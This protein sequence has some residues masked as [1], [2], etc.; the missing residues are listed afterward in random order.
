MPRALC[1]YR[2]VGATNPLDVVTSSVQVPV[3]GAEL[4]VLVVGSAAAGAWPAILMIHENRGMVPYMVAV[5]ADL[6]AAGYRVVAPDLL[7]RIGGTASFADDP[8]SVSTRQIDNDTHVADLRVVYDSMEAAGSPP[9]VVGFCFGAEMGWQLITQRTPRGAVLY[10]GIGPEPEA[11]RRITSPVYAVYA[12]DDPRVNAT[13]AGLTPA[14][15][16][17]ECEFTLE[18]YP[19]TKHAFH[20]RSRPERF[21][22]AAAD[23]VWQR[24]LTYLD[25]L[26]DRDR[27]FDRDGPFDRA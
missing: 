1:Q 19:G 15:A 9:A 14:L 24:T 4:D 5:A 21:D 8:T 13:L 26:F 7:S 23:F 10:Y 27:L 20:D 18:S 25:K 12:Q 11:T 2:A 3:P 22:A 16:D 17:S 6:A